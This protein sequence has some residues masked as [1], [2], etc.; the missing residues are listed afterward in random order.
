[1]NRKLTCI[2][3]PIGCVLEVHYNDNE[4]LSVQGNLCPRGRDYAEKELFEWT[5]SSR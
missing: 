2:V 5:M 4:I 1:M 3:C